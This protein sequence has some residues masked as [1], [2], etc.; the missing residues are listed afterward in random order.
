[1]NTKELCVLAC[2]D[3]FV[4]KFLDEGVVSCLYNNNNNKNKKDDSD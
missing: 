3:K 2:L 1:M 4:V